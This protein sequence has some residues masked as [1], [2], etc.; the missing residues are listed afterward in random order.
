MKRL[1]HYLFLISICSFQ[2]HSQNWTD[3]L[4]HEKNVVL[5][6]FTGIY[7][8]F[9]PQGHQVAHDIDIANPGRVIVI[10]IHS[11]DTYSEPNPGSGHPDFRTQWGASLQSMSGLTGFPS[12]MVN[13]VSFPNYAQGK[14][15]GRTYW[16][17]ASNEILN[18]G[19]TADANIGARSLWDESTRQLS[20]D[21]EVYYHKEQ[22][23]FNRLTIALTESKV[24]GYQGGGSSNYEHNHILRELITGVSSGSWTGEKIDDITA[25]EWKTIHIDYTVDPSIDIDNCELGIFLTEFS[26]SNILTGVKIHPKNDSTS[27]QTSSSITALSMQNKLR[28]YPNPSSENVFF[29]LPSNSKGDIMIWDLL[30]NLVINKSIQDQVTNIDTKNFNSGLYFYKVQSGLNSFT[31]KLMIR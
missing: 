14:A 8:G 9:C 20:I 1:I 3:T 30:G 27:L 11:S 23:L 4:Y 2:I 21:V 26:N 18:S 25:G 16:E 15:M 17:D 28:V 22:N 6:E 29:Q 5:E 13:R 19:D 7:C 24:F 12:G 10:G 31:G